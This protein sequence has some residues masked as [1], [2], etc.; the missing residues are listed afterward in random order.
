MGKMIDGAW[1]TQWYQPDKGGGF[2]R[3]DTVFRKR[4]A[5]ERMADGGF[6]LYVSYACPWAHRTLILRA[7]HGLEDLVP[8]SVVHPVMGDEGWVFD[9]SAPGATPDRLLGKTR[10]HE[11]YT[12]ADSHYSGRVTVPVLWSQES[13]GIVN[14]E[15]R[16]IIEMFDVA[17]ALL[18]GKRRLWAPEMVAEID[19]M[20]DANYDAVNNGVYRAGF[21]TSQS[22][23]E[24]AAEALFARLDVLEDHLSRRRF[25][26]GDE[27]T[28]ADVC[29]FVTLFRFDAVYVGHFKCNRRRIV[30]YPHLWSYTREIFQMETVR[31]TCFVDHSREHYY[32]SHPSINPTGI[33]PVGPTLDFEAPHDRHLL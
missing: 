19:A 11:L 8:V 23:Y 21:A 1:T 15:S 24:S 6:H 30:D 16:Q 5:S 33:V 20:I 3:P 29:L 7:W 4:L 26:C 32:R 18:S 14:N 13:N 31:T 27:F 2:I 10:L 9:E 28:T 12:L 22:A 17:G 25:L